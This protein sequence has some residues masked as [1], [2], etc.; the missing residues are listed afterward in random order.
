M[1]DKILA[2][3]RE[4]KCML[5]EVIIKDKRKMAMNIDV[6]KLKELNLRGATVVDGISNT[7]MISSIVANYIINNI[8]SLLCLWSMTQCPNIQQEY[9]RMKRRR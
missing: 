5:K 8:I 9:L 2:T 3:M 1:L 6:Y 4:F 7:G